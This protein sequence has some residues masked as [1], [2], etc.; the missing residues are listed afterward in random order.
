M[1]PALLALLSGEPIM[2]LA[3]GS[4]A[5]AKVLQEATATVKVNVVS[6]MTAVPFS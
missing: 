6:F 2:P 1:L 4:A 5:T 3:A